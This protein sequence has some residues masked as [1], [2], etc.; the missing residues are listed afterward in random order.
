MWNYKNLEYI[1]TI[2]IPIHIISFSIFFHDFTWWHI[3]LTFIMW[4]IIDGLGVE[5]CFHRIL[6]HGAL[7]VSKTTEYILS[8]F[9]CLG[10]Q[11]SPL[12]WASLHKYHHAYSDTEKDIH[13]PLNGGWFNSF[14]GWYVSPERANVPLDRNMIKDNVQSFMHRHYKIIF[15]GTLFNVLILF[16]PVIALF[17]LVYP[18]MLSFYRVNAVN[19]FC[20]KT[21]LGLKSYTTKDTSHDLPIL[22]IFSWGL[23]L[24]NTHHRFPTDL[25]FDK[26]VGFDPMRILLFWKRDA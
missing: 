26:H 19:T 25:F 16:G 20:H 1:L 10:G 15:W 21:R 3:L 9:G 4:T 17:G 12:W 22:G 2:V 24:H 5:L 8:Y 6:S 18:A 23:G 11:W 13:S 14:Y 7:K